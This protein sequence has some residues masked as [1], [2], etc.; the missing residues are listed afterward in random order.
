MTTPPDAHGPDDPPRDP[1]WGRTGAV[2]FP[3]TPGTGAVPSPTAPSGAVPFADPPGTG[4][5]P[6][7]DLP[8]MD[9]VPPSG[10]PGT[11][12]VPFPSSSPPAPAP[13]TA[14][15]PPDGPPRTSRLA[16]TA[17][18][19]GLLGLVPLAL[20]FGIAALVRRRRPRKGKGLALAG[21]A[22]SAAWSAA[23][24]LL[25]PLALEALFSVERDASGAISESRPTLFTALRKGDCFT[26]YDHGEELRMVTAVPCTE[27]HTGEVVMRTAL[28]DGPWPGDDRA[29]RAVRVMCGREIVPLRKSPLAPALELYTEVPNV[30]G[31]KTGR[32]E[33]TCAAHHDGERKGRLAETVNPK[34]GSYESLARWRCIKGWARE[35]HP[36]VSPVSCSRPH[37][38]QVFAT[39][40]IQPGL[41]DDPLAYPPYPGVETLEQQVMSRCEA[42][43]VRTW[44][45]LPRPDLQLFVVPPSPYDWETGIRK[46][47]CM[48]NVPGE[49]LKG[50]LAPR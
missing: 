48:V 20:A 15:A 25:A 43:A 4:A 7:A 44:P 19:T 8:E 40:E 11:G 39:Y 38:A 31:W 5:L 30:V 45:R 26:G 22:A 9:A 24:G 32:R 49:R 35:K 12:A 10:P 21:I 14:P 17:L 34:L 46:V 18:V 42:L 28:P 41:E 50:S 47:T 36:L 6:F 33:I 37:F 27:P 29:E 2:P 23:I 1:A 13:P 16:V 3:D